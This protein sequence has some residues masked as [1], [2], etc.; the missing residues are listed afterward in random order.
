[1]IICHH[2][3]INV[4]FDPCYRYL[5]LFFIG[6]MFCDIFVQTR[7]RNE[8][9]HSTV[10]CSKS[11]DPPFKISSLSQEPARFFEEMKIA[12]SYI[13]WAFIDHCKHQKV[14]DMD[15]ESAILFFLKYFT[16]ARITPAGV[17]WGLVFRQ[18]LIV[19]FVSPR[20]FELAKTAE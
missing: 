5:S 14:N 19:Q 11:P 12:I 16:I 7:E 4:S 15:I 18:S 3:Q 2:G 8:R 9:L 17:M 1:M 10:Q 13:Y 20:C 6:K